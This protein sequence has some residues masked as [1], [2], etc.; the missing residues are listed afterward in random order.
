[1]PGID[2]GAPE[3]TDTSSGS[4]GVAEA[5]AELLLDQASAASTC[6]FKLVGIGPCVVVEPGA[7]LGGDGEA[8][9]DRQ[10]EI[11]HLGEVGALAAEQRLHR[12][13]PS[14]RPPPNP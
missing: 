7:D 3:R 14:A 2:T 5:G 1:M 11:A 13:R 4:L 6:A 9:R 10:A 8:R 12:R